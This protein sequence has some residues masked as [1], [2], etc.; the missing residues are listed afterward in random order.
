MT[1]LGAC[2]A[3]FRAA[4]RAGSGFAIR[5]RRMAGSVM[6]DDTGLPTARTMLQVAYMRVLL[7]CWSCR[8]QCDA[9]RGRRST[10]R[11]TAVDTRCR[12][13]RWVCSANG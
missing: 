2:R 13:P 11:A 3:R 4:L 12:R 7:T 6:R 9:G 10:G 5:A 1:A 8:H